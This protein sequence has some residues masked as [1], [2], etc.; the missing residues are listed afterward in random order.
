M[1]LFVPQIS[2]AV[3][4]WLGGGAVFRGLVATF[5]PVGFDEAYYYLYSRHLAWSY[6]DHPL[7]VALTTGIG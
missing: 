6:F 5:L 4:W 1:K 7:M 3:W 2:P